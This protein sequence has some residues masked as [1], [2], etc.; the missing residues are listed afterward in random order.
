MSSLIRLLV[1]SVI[2]LLP[3]AA[4]AD[5]NRQTRP[6]P[7]QAADPG[8][9]PD[10]PV[11]PLP[12][13]DSKSP[14]LAVILS[15][16]G[17]WAD[18]DRDFGLALQKRGIATVGFDCLKFFWS[19]KNPTQVTAAL[20]TVLRYYLTAWDKQKVLLLG[21]SFGA[22]WLPLVINSLPV[23]LQNRICLV[24]LLAPGQ[25]TNIEIKFGDWFHDVRRPGAIDV[26]QEAKAL[27]HP[28][29]CVYG[30]GEKHDSL[31][32]L[33]TG[34]N[35]KIIGMPGGH[36]FHKDYTPIEDAIISGLNATAAP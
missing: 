28:I 10:L 13:P 23:D 25:Y 21:Y 31:C 5:S 12:V 2:L 35:R 24:A 32:P 9:P 6:A 8:P 4:W 27:R 16:D 20:E 17:G 7:A 36:H 29:I 15:G 26:T 3:T 1:L 18:L 33:L 14:V 19:P 11:V 34:I 22:S 30:L